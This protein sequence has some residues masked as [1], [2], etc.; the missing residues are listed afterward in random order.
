MSQ[1]RKTEVIG[2]APVRRLMGS[3]GCEVVARDAVAKMRTHLM[4]TAKK[5]SKKASEI[6]ENAG[7]KKISADDVALAINLL[8]L[9]IRRW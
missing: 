2:L 9:T 4:E 1:K 5:I 6:M 7:R 3:M 8:G